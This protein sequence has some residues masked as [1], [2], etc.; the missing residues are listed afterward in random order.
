MTKKSVN[1]QVSELPDHIKGKLRQLARDGKPITHMAQQLGLDYAV[2]QAYLWQSGTLPWQGAKSIVSRRLQSLRTATKRQDR[3]T[4]VN[5]AKEQVDYLYY[6][7]CQ[8]RAQLEKVK[9]S[10][11]RTSADNP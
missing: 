5:D 4:L 6:A 8:L 11:P 3:D 1:K 10:L 9:K 7:A 2:V